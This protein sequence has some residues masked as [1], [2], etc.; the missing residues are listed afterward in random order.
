[1]RRLLD[2]F[3]FSLYRFVLIPPALIAIKLIALLPIP[4]LKEMV[5]DRSQVNW[6]PLPSRPI[7]IHAAS[8]EIEYAKSVIRELKRQFP[9]TLILVTYFSPSAKKL[10][11]KFEGIDLAIPLPWDSRTRVKQFLKFYHPKALLIARTDVWPEFAYQCQKNGIPAILFAATFSEHSSRKGWIQTPLTRFALHCLNRIICVSETDAQNLAAMNIQTNLVIGGDTRFDQVIHR[12]KNP[13]PVKS[14]L[15]PAQETWVLGSTWPED[16]D[17]LWPAIEKWC[18]SGK[19]LILA[20]HEIHDNRIED[21]SRKILASG[22]T[23]IRYSKATDWKTENILIV[24]KMGCLHELYGWGTCAFVG[25][26]FKS[27]IHSVMEPLSQGIPTLVGP[28]HLNNR[29]ALQFQHFHLSP[30]IMMVQPIANAQD[31]IY[32]LEKI[33]SIPNIPSLISAQVS[34]HSGATRQVIQWVSDETKKGP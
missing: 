15:K 7:W 14:E 29:E 5:Q 12:T 22:L 33:N 6:Q 10:I 17:T 13:L 2:L 11:Q 34:A 19:K 31:A 21:L 23:S 4:K 20:P 8:G 25:G 30:E 18:K 1:M 28:Y 3:S 27:K 24:D 9:Q 16:E 26:S 32:T